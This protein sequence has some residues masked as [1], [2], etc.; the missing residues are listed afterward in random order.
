MRSLERGGESNGDD[1]E[2]GDPKPPS[3]SLSEQKER[4]ATVPFSPGHLDEDFCPRQRPAF[5]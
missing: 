3:V 2:D 4:G 1:C 5:A